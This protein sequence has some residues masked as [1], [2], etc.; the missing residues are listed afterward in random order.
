ML[1]HPEKEFDSLMCLNNM[2]L[3][4]RVFAVDVC[5]CVLLSSN[6]QSTESQMHFQDYSVASFKHTSQTVLILLSF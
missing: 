5:W 1:S 3:L 6:P 4:N 2:N